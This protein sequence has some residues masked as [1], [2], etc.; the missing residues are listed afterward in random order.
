MWS[1]LRDHSLYIARRSND[2]SDWGNT[3]KEGLTNLLNEE[4]IFT[5]KLLTG[6]DALH[7]YK[8]SLQVSAK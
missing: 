2:L 5:V 4:I 7:I 1:F 8:V 6:G 3:L